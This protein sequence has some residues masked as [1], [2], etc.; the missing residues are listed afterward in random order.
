VGKVLAKLEELGIADRTV[1]FFMSDNGGVHRPHHPGDVPP[2]SNSPLREGK[3]QLYEGGIREP[4][5][6]RWPGAVKPGSVSDVPVISN[7]FFPTIVAAAGV[8]LPGPVDGLD[9]STVLKGR[10]PVKRDALYW[11]FPHYAS[12]G[13]AAAIR[14]G[15]YKLLEFF[16]TGKVELYNL[17]QDIGEQNDLSTRLPRKVAELRRKLQKW[18][19]EVGAQRLAPNPG[20]ASG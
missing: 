1:V 16:E 7:D 9:L 11:Y 3:A 8:R 19:D 10:G 14:Q 2:T 17:A 5:I 20:R 6:V 15:D 4:L 18:M 13:P 12:T